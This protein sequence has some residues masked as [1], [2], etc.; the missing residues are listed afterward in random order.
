MDYTKLDARLSEAL[1]DSD[2]R[3]GF[4]V[5]VEISPDATADEMDRLARLGVSRL[6]GDETIVTARLSRDQL[7]RVSELSAVRQVR[8]RRRL[9]HA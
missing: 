5:F 3:A 6:S 2:A 7:D 4:D 1:A 8:L 9:R